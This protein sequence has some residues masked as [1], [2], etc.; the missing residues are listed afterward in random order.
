MD[1]TS[2]TAKLGAIKAG[3]DAVK[4]L[5]DLGGQPSQ[6][7]AKRKLVFGLVTNASQPTMMIPRMM[8]MRVAVL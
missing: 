1:L 7:E 4:G 6:I 2:V 3:V 5:S 8:T